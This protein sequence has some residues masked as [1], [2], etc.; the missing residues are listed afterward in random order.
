MLKPWS[1]KSWLRRI[2]LSVT[3]LLFVTPVNARESAVAEP[4]PT[5]APT[6][7]EALD[8]PAP[9]PKIDA[10]P[11][12]WVVKDADTTIY[13]FGTIHMLKPGYS[14]FDEG[15]KD[16]FD[17]SDELVLE[18]TDADPVEAIKIFTELGID[19]TGVALRAKMNDEERK[20]Y[21]EGMAKLGYNVAKF[22]P[23]QPWYAAMQIQLAGIAQAGMGASD[24]VETTLTAVAE[25]RKMPIKGLE[26]L[27]FQI[28]KL[29]TLPIPVQ[30]KFLNDSLTAATDYTTA[31]EQMLAS[32]AKPDPE[33]L[34]QYMN[35]G[36]ADPTLYDAM[37]TSRNIA[38]A[39]WVKKRLETPGTTF[40]AVGAGHLSGETSVP[41]LLTKDGLTVERV[42]Y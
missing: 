26:T 2:A 33:A 19:K 32:W 39:E 28:E 3:P 16:A 17:K 9:A 35:D 12:L 31:M 21:E 6:D 10:D 14:W 40:M 37:L 25:Q 4:T 23:M 15:V 38:W 11:A 18:L 41:A 34:A 8:L 24:G 27:R 30:I 42:N 22:E 13:M 36:L 29:A 20:T 1:L 7:V 5:E